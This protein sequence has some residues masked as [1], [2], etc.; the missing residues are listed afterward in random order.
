MKLAQQHPRQSTSSADEHPQLLM[1]P[2]A[3][4]GPT[5]AL[6]NAHRH[7]PPGRLSISA[8]QRAQTAAQHPPG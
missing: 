6:A 3:H 2:V 5:Q 1:D 8:D 4:V 7:P